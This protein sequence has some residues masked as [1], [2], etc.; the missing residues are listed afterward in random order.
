LQPDRILREPEVR[1]LTGISRTTRWRLRKTGAFP[2]PIN[3]FGRVIGWRKSV[4][5]AWI[6]SRRPN[7]VA[8]SKRVSSQLNGRT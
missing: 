1:N 3:I 4:I 2:E 7:D 8:R 5:Q 6:S